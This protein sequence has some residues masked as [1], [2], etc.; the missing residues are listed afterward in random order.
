[1]TAT[2][3]EY[4]TR[5]RE[6]AVKVRGVRFLHNGRVPSQGFDCLGLVV[7]IQR[8]AGCSDFPDTE[9]FWP[10]DWHVHAQT[11]LYLEGV[12]P[13]SIAVPNMNMLRP[14]DVVLFRLGM[15]FPG[16]GSMRVQHIGVVM[17]TGADI[18]FLQCLQGRG[19]IESSLRER[20]WTKCFVQ[21]GRSYALMR[22]LG[23]AGGQ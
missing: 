15:I 6:E 5:L 21:G 9:R 3:A 17:S 19:V 8:A 2:R 22:Y 10:S 7:W 16:S 1:V 23:E 20:A 12:A 11:E 13:H 18:R 14:G 4:E